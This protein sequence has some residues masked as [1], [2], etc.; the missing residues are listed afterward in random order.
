M[1]MIILYYISDCRSN[2]IRGLEFHVVLGESVPQPQSHEDKPWFHGGID[3]GQAEDKLRRIPHDGAF[4]VRLVQH[5]D[6]RFGI[7]FR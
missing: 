5:G 4:L 3:R 7:S 1:A 2:P 6:S